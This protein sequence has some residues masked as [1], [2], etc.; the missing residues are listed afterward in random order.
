MDGILKWSPFIFYLTVYSRHCYDAFWCADF[1]Y[2]ICQISKIRGQFWGSKA[3]ERHFL[4]DFIICGV[5]TPGWA[6]QSA[7]KSKT[8]LIDFILVHNLIPIALGV[9]TLCI[10]IFRSVRL[11]GRTVGRKAAICAQNH[12]LVAT[13][14]TYVIL[15]YGQSIAKATRLTLSAWVLS[16]Y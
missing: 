15:F 11:V 6:I 8:F 2:Y 10:G 16:S 1:G 4:A 14:E 9:T 13:V 5:Q 7:D 3:F 12:S